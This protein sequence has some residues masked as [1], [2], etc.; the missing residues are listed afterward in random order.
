[1]AA[2][3]WVKACQDYFTKEPNGRKIEISEFKALSDEDKDEMYEMLK[4]E[5]YE[6]LPKA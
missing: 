1:M 4:A 6:L 2:M 5:G 3:S